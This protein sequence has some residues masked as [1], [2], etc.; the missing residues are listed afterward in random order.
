[1]REST[2]GAWLFGL[3]ITFMVIFVGF[4]AVMISYSIAFKTK[5]EVV[6][7]IEKY[8]GFVDGNYTG[9]EADAS[10]NSVWLIN[11]YLVNSGYANKGACSCATNDSTNNYC[12]GATDLGDY[13]RLEKAE[14]SKKNY[15]YCINFVNSGKDDYGRRMGYFDF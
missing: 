5:N 12:Y 10:P 14:V 15:F 7:I 13:S 2:G 8:E 6:G 9:D 1:M 4:L 11:N 3:V